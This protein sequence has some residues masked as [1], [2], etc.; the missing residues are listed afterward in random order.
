MTRVDFYI[1]EAPGR[2]ARDRFVCRL[3]EKAAGQGHRIFVQ[4][5]GPEHPERLDGLMWTFRD[6][7][8]LSHVFSDEAASLD[9]Q[10][11]SAVVI[12]RGDDVDVHHDL[13]INTADEVPL[14]FSR[15]DRVAE[16]V[17]GD[18]AGRDAGRQRYRFYRD[19]GYDLSTHR[20]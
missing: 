11:L 14:F 3:A 8:F 4:P 13:L 1:L 12:G 2:D 7:A 16:I 5:A 15:F 17:P 6:G 20:I 18:D 19:R 9:P 10:G